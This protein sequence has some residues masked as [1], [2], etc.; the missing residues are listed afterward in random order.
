ML[1]RGQADHRQ[2]CVAVAKGGDRGVVPVGIFRAT[3]R[4]KRDEAR[5]KRAVARRLALRD[6][7]ERLR[8]IQERRAAAKGATEPAPA[9][10][11]AGNPAAPGEGDPDPEE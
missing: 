1:S 2:L 7:V 3:L 5:A 9:G 11:G 10:E 4:A 6:V 8:A